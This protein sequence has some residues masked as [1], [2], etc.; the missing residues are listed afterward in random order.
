MLKRMF[1]F[2]VLL[3]G[4]LFLVNSV[5][6]PHVR[7]SRGH[8]ELRLLSLQKGR[9]VI[10]QAIAAH[11]GL[12]AWQSKVDM[13]LHLTD[14]W[15]SLPGVVFSNLIDMWPQREVKTEQHHLLHQL[16]SRLEMSTAAGRHVWGYRDFQPWA[17]IN[18]QIDPENIRRADL[19]LPLSNYLLALPYRFLDDGAYPHFVNEI[20]AGGRIFDRVRV[21]FG[22]N[23]GTYPPNEYVADFDQATGR[24]ARLEFTLREKLPSCVTLRADFENYQQFD[25]IWMPTQIEFYL[26][27]PFM[28]LP[29]HRWQ[30]SEV[31]FNTGVAESFLHANPDEGVRRVDYIFLNF[32][33]K[34][35]K[36][37]IF[38][39]AVNL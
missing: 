24:L 12:A 10:T 36:V 16:A 35:K 31:R 21:V 22:L 20:K 15:N 28:D 4:G 3:I 30:I 25:G 18:D 5:V 39:T 9:E 17:F 26:A 32:L 11:G 7:R 14:Q 29:L 1:L 38:Q 37:K 19:T 23:A 2:T 8:N 34:K 6:I 33:A 27:K 13:G